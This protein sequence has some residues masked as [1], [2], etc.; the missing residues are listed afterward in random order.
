[1][2]IENQLKPCPLC[3]SKDI[4]HGRMDYLAYGVMCKSCGC[5]ISRYPENFKGGV[6]VLEKFCPDEESGM[7]VTKALWNTRSQDNGII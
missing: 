6:F 2:T 7:T 3:S 4:F 1:M 5:R